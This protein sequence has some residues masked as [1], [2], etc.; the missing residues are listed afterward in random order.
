MDRFDIAE[1]HA[2]LEWDYNM[3][4]WLQERPSNMRRREA[5]AVQLHRMQFRPRPDLRFETL[6]EEGRDVYLS[7]VLR[8]KLPRDEE[9]NQRIK[10]FFA[11]D[12]LK[13][14]YPLVYTE[15]FAVPAH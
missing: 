5:T 4:G 8:W 13:E 6:T 7:N 12:W 3:G 15:L 11:E 1:G 9:Q 10:E 14:H 2:V